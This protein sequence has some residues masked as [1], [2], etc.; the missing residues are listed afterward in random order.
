M[1]MGEENCIDTRRI[2]TGLYQPN[3]NA[4]A[5]VKEKALRPM[6]DKGRWSKTMF[7]N[8]RPA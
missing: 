7:I 5:R 6:T 8:P 4:S 3:S 2:F 1:S